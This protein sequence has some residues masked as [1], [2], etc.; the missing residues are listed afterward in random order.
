MAQKTGNSSLPPITKRRHHR[1]RHFPHRSGPKVTPLQSV[2]LDVLSTG[3]KTGRHMRSLLLHRGAYSSLIPF[4]RVIRRLKKAGWITARRI[5]RDRGEYR[6]AQCLY[7]LTERGWDEVVAARA[8]FE[9][10]AARHRSAPSRHA[11]RTN[12]TWS[13]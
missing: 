5:P 6:G 11:L 10:C 4:Y 3:Q 13:S 8:F 2:Y 7:E 9:R 1:V 12:G